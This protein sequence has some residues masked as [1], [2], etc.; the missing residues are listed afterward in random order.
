MAENTTTSDV[1]QDRR[2][3]PGLDGRYEIDKQGNVYAMFPFRDWPIGRAAKS[4]V[5]NYGYVFVV[6]AI[7]G[8]KTFF[9]HR[10]LMLTF[11]PI[12]NPHE[13]DVNHIDGKKDNN[14]LSNLEWLTHKAN[15]Q[16]AHKVL[17]AWAANGPR[18]ENTI[19][20]KLTESDVR[21]IRELSKA[22]KSQRDIGR[23]FGVTQE[24]ISQIVRG[25]SWAHIK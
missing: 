16:H 22:G 5:N 21:Q 10:L 23:Q 19:T 12:D 13:M 9:L 24:N 4:Y 25:K 11:C 8:G 7:G 3:I 17:D 18:G 6:L 14:D 1:S 15:I 20:A 2:P